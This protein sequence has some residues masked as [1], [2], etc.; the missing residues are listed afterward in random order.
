MRDPKFL[1]NFF[2]FLP[3]EQIRQAERAKRRYTRST[4]GE[5]EETDRLEDK[6][7]VKREQRGLARKR[8]G[9]SVLSLLELLLFE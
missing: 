5:Q 2:S 3:S 4:D 8:E 6:D 9:L 7:A 1:F